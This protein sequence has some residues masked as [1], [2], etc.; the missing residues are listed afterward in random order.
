VPVPGATREEEA[1]RGSC[2]SGAAMSAPARAR[3][4]A[5]RGRETCR[6]TTTKLGRRDDGSPPGAM[7]A[8]QPGEAATV[9]ACCSAA[10]VEVHHSIA[11]PGG[12]ERGENKGRPQEGDGGGAEID[13]RRSRC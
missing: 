4:A 6:A 3:A 12:R 2:G 1:G 13:A 9:R 7:D 11:T 8:L 10:T 5:P